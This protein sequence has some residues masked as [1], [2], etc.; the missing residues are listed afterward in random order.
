MMP[1]L[2]LLTTTTSMLRSIL[3]AGHMIAV[4]QIDLSIAVTVCHMVTQVDAGFFEVY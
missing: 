1:D 2:V 3:S 4:L